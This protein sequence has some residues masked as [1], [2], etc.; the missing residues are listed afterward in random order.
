MMPQHWAQPL[1]QEKSRL[2]RLMASSNGHDVLV[3]RV[4]LALEHFQATC[5]SLS[6]RTHGLVLCS[7]REEVLTA[8]KVARR[9]AQSSPSLDFQREDILGAFSGSVCGETEKD[10]NGFFMRSAVDA[11]RAKILFVAHKFETGYDN[12][13]V[14]C[15]YMFRKIDASTLATQVLLPHCSKRP[16][17]IR[18]I[19]IDFANQDGQLLSV[20]WAHLI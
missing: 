11:K 10:L 17:K 1:C 14:T 15:L 20:A 7:S 2:Q 16:G 12:P 6:Y 9:L 3:A 19:T 13:A 18:P 5:G 8:T 4:R